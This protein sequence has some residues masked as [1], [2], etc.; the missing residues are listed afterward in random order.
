[1]SNWFPQDWTLAKKASPGN[2]S[3]DFM[4]QQKH[5]MD[6]KNLNE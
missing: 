4:S 2:V 5:A 3:T 1:M 6:F